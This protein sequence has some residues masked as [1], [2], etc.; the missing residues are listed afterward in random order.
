M[1]PKVALPNALPLSFIVTVPVGDVKPI[2]ESLQLTLL[3][4]QSTVMVNVMVCPALL[5]LGAPVMVVVV[6]SDAALALPATLNN[7]A[8]RITHATTLEAA[9]MRAAREILRDILNPPHANAQRAASANIVATKAPTIPGSEYPTRVPD[10]SRK[11]HSLIST[12]HQRKIETETK[13]ACLRRRRITFSK[14][15]YPEPTP[16]ISATSR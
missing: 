2:G 10:A 16:P 7:P 4:L 3:G 13:P 11:K 15:A 9:P 1:A 8:N 14:K 12:C 6:V 5:E